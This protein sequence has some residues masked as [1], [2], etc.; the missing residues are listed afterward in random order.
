ML[1]IPS[2]FPCTPIAGERGTAEALLGE[3]NKSISSY[4]RNFAGNPKS[5]QHE[6]TKPRTVRSAFPRKDSQCF[7][8]KVLL[9]RRFGDSENLRCGDA[10]NL[11]TGR[12][13]WLQN[14][15]PGEAKKVYL[16]GSA[17]SAVVPQITT[18]P[19]PSGRTLHASRRRTV[20]AAEVAKSHQK[21]NKFYSTSTSKNGAIIRV[22]QNPEMIKTSKMLRKI[23]LKKH[24]FRAEKYS[25]KYENLMM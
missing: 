24:G 5:A 25:R 16:T 21:S 19:L 2:A 7:W 13:L 4:T 12:K 23:H 6:T 3:T 1:Q 11:K 9:M 18:A 15:D 14:T 22:N 17:R 10:E 20:F 8:I